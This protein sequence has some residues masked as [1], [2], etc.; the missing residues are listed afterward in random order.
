[1]KAL[2]K[3]F[4]ILT[5]I[6]LLIFAFTFPNVSP[7]YGPG[8]DSSYVWALNWLFVHDYN[9]LTSLIYPFGPLTVLKCSIG[10]GNNFI[11]FLAF[12]SFIKC[13]FIVSGF[14]VSGLFTDRRP[15]MLG[16]KHKAFRWFMP[17][18]LLWVA[19]YYANV[20]IL[21]IFSCLFLSLLFIQRRK[22]G[23][24]LFAVALAV[25]SLF[26]KVSIG[27]SALA[28]VLVSMLL[29]FAEYHSVRSLLL[30]CLVF[31]SVFAA[32][33]FVVLHRPSVV[34][35]WMV[36]V[37]HLVFGYGGLSLDYANHAFWMILWL[38]SLVLL[39]LLCREKKFRYAGFMLMVPVF[40]FYKHGIIR[41]D[42]YHFFGLIF[43]MVVFWMVMTLLAFRRRCVVLLVGAIS[44]FSL[45]MNAAE[46][47]GAKKR[48]QQFCY[49]VDNVKGP[50]FHYKSYMKDANEYSA[51]R[52]QA[53]QLPDT[54]LQKI[55]NA[56]I[57][58][59][60][61]EFS[62]VAQNKLNWQPRTSLGSALSPWLE[63]KS[64]RNFS[65]S[66]D[67]AR[68]VLWHFQNDTYGKRS[69]SID[70]RYFLNDEPE[71]VLNMMQNYKVVASTDRLLLLERVASPVPCN[72]TMGDHLSVQWGE[73]VEVPSYLDAAV[74][75]KV[76][77]QKSFKGKLRSLLYKDEI[78]TVDYQTEDGTIYS[79]RY[80]P[81]FSAEGLWCSPL[82]QQPCD[83]VSEPA[84]TR[85]RF[86]TGNDRLMRPAL[87]LQFEYLPMDAIPG[88]PKV[89]R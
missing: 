82:V 87:D 26:I 4:S 66:D 73:W 2:V 18:I 39:P 33:A 55:G 35:N 61:F 60:P 41:E 57:D 45:M 38:L 81:A 16:R 22:F 70:D 15:N 72:P 51:W 50:F 84:V 37:A 63:K 71:V 11:L 64:A 30:Q 48:I 3:D 27:V 1:M 9:T 43:F 32:M 21:I 5:A 7:D 86:R 36:G 8:L 76:N 59:Y 58:I 52:L 78:Y 31:V 40:A 19:C 13:L 46:M 14:L 28:V 80:D 89:K 67:A 34:Y 23:L 20:D 17:T 65:N 85:I 74:R 10:V 25:L 56:S 79:Y 6:T 47:E 42:L 49:G 54:V 24:F 29:Y 62:Y 77:S 69:V 44:V 88:L 53:V 83:T 75:V 68:F 12:Y